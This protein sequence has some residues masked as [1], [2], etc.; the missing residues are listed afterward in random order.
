MWAALERLAVCLTTYPE[1]SPKSIAIFI[2]ILQE[3]YTKTRSFIALTN[4]RRLIRMTYPLAL[5]IDPNPPASSPP[6]QPQVMQAAILNLLQS[7]VIIDF[8]FDVDSVLFI[9]PQPPLPDSSL[10]PLVF[11]QLLRLIAAAIGYRNYGIGCSSVTLFLFFFQLQFHSH[12]CGSHST[13][14]GTQYPHA[15]SLHPACYHQ[16]L[17]LHFINQFNRAKKRQPCILP[18]SR[19]SFRCNC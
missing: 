12:S 1:I 18:A 17:R 13:A 11:T 16:Q 5:Y 7:M 14:S 9:F 4:V 15:N 2:Q 3:L 6:N 19:E 8:I 10:Y